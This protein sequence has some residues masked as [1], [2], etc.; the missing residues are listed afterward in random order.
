MQQMAMVRGELKSAK[1]KK[2]IKSGNIK[3]RRFK[4]QLDKL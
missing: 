3:L 1:F 2:D 4:R